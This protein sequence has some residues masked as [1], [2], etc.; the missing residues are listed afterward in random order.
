MLSLKDGRGESQREGLVS[1]SGSRAQDV[2]EFVP[3]LP[4][5]ARCEHLDA[6]A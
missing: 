2:I 5:G 4:A 1:E 3:I 6:G